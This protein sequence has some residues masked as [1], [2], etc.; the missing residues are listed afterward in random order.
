LTS[1]RIG[2]N[3]MIISVPSLGVKAEEIVKAF[4][5][6][7]GKLSK[8]Q[9]DETVK[10]DIGKMTAGLGI[11]QARLPGFSE[12]NVTF[13]ANSI[14]EFVKRV[15]ANPKDMEKLESEPI[16]TIY[17]ASESNPDRSRPE[18]EESFLL[19]Y[20]KL[21]S[22]GEKNRKIVEMMKNSALV[23]ITYACAGG[24]IALM[25]AVSNVYFSIG[26]G[27]PQSALVITAD[28]A[29]Y[30]NERAPNAEYTQGA[31]A[32]LLWI[33]KDPELVSIIYQNGRGDFHMPLSDFTKF[34]HETPMVHG[35]FS[36]R[37]YV[38]TVA[39][40]LEHLERG[41]DVSL[42]DMEFFVT[43]VPFPK[44]AIY[45]AS[46]LF[47]HYLKNY[48]KELFIEMQKRPELGDETIKAGE[49]ITDL[50]DKKFASFNSGGAVLEEHDIIQYIENDPEIDAYWNWLKRLRNQKE[51]DQFVDSLHIK[52]A[53]E[54]PSEVGNSYSSSAFVAFAS[55]IKN[56]EELRGERGRFGILSF[57][58][59]GAIARSV[60]VEIHASEEIVNKRLVL[61]MPA[62]IYIDS[63]QYSE[64][65][66][67]LVRG[68]AHRM[69]NGNDLIEKDKK[70]LKSERLGK[71][72]HIRKRNANSTGEYVYSDGE[73][74][75]QIVVRY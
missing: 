65:H 72:F 16:R 44:Q 21:L 10:N 33:T 5:K 75:T 63:D 46:F 74:M 37:T 32:S 62:A 66:K 28:T 31:G 13:V 19:V 54:I 70:F 4:H 8:E 30:D 52:N 41:G 35:K 64:L 43:H 26:T 36:E 20:S 51:F 39:K 71:G 58:G 1:P 49:R 53:L 29:I 57:Y 55:L 40:S 7:N 50:M 67:E 25:D 11:K 22:E 56:S 34:G 12:S 60:S 6:R 24:G 59:S 38:Y 15:T 18:V 27:K 9:F 61:N 47:A 45:F 69:L 42:K 17:Y 2:I 48:Q 68:D 14:Y 73:K 23:P 3:E